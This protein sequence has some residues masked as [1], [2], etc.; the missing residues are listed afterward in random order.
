MP[1]N[2]SDHL[3]QTVGAKLREARLAKKYTQN[4]LAQPDFSVSYIS[5]IE[6][7]QIQPSLRALE[8]F[9]QRLGMN[10]THLLSPHRRVTSG[11]YAGTRNGSQAYEEWEWLLVEAQIALHEGQPTQAIDLVQPLLVQKGE[12]R[13]QIAVSYVLGRAYLAGGYVQESESTL[14]EAASMAKA[15]GDPLYPRILNVQGAVYAAMHRMEQA[16]HFQ[17]ASLAALEQWPILA[18]D[19][20]F[21]AQVYTS[22]GQAYSQLGAFAQALE[23][24]QQ[25]LTLIQPQTPSQDSQIAYRNLSTFYQERTELIW[26]ALS[27]AKW[28]QTDLQS[29]LPAVKSQIQ[30]ALGRALLKSQPDEAYVY[31]LALSQEAS[32][33]QDPLAQTSAKV[34]LAAWFLAHGDLSQAESSV[35]EALE[36]ASPFGASMIH[37]DALILQGKLAYAQQAYEQ[38]DQSFSAGLM[39]LEHLHIFEDLI[40]HLT[41]YARLLEE[42]GLLHAA[43]LYWKRAYEQQQTKVSPLSPTQMC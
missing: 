9:A 21:L 22:L 6:R 5:A 25:V 12:P 35:H 14:A 39:M 20:F 4:Q 36:L 41:S 40:E 24:F 42:R 19:V 7:G 8:I 28:L 37:A 26:A 38:G 10:S 1:L 16:V 15:A 32:I 2:P 29:Q 33:R 23:M 43:L 13:Q 31:L 11:P 18:N 27:H 17:Q 3:G 30:H 34:H